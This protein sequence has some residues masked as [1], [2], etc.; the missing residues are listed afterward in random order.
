[1]RTNSASR[2]LNSR[3]SSSFSAPRT[4]WWAEL[5]GFASSCGTSQWASM[6][7]GA[8]INVKNHWTDMVVVHYPNCNP[9]VKRY[10]Y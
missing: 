1:V 9:A 5:G 2:V 8:Q 6:R 10:A 4:G 7:A 3:A